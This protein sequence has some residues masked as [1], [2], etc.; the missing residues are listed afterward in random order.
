MKTSLP[1][2]ASSKIENYKDAVDF[3]SYG[4]ALRAQYTIY[5]K[6]GLELV[7]PFEGYKFSELSSQCDPY[8]FCKGVNKFCIRYSVAE[9]LPKEIVNYTIKR[10]NPGFSISKI[11]GMNDNRQRL[12]NY[13]KNHE[14]VLVN[15]DELYRRISG[16]IFDKKEF[17]ALSLIVFENILHDKYSLNLSL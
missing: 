11:F 16:N 7:A 8:I 14:S 15:S 3:A 1:L 2:P 12:M 6:F 9:L 5:Q 17:L 10:A 4:G 13:V